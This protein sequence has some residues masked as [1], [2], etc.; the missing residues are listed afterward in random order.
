MAVFRLQVSSKASILEELFV[1]FTDLRTPMHPG[2]VSSGPR[3]FRQRD[4]ACLKQPISGRAGGSFPL[5]ASV[6][7]DGVN[8][9]VFSRH[10]SRVELLLFADAAAAQQRE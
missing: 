2:I 3:N 6:F 5:G 7:A 8:F 1:S 4:P 10:A 9:S